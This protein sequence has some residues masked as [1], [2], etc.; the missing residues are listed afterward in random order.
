MSPQEALTLANLTREARAEAKRQLA[1]GL[2]SLDEVIHTGCCNTLS[3]TAL[4]GVLPWWGPQRVRRMCRSVG[5][6]PDRQIG[7]LTERQR[8]LLVAAYRRELAHMSVGRR[9]R[10]LRGAR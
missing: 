2:A 4:L 10:N 5:L 6:D 3:I 1:G 8:G 7:R 9:A